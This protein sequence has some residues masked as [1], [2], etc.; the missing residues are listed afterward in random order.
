MNNYYQKAHL[1]KSLHKDNNMNNEPIFIVG[2]ERSGTTLFRLMLSHHPKISVC[3]EFEYAVDPI[4]FS[5]RLNDREALNQ[6]SQN[7]IFKSHGVKLDHEQSWS[8]NMQK[9]LKDFQ[10][11]EQKELSTAIVHKN[12][13]RLLR[14][15]P[16]AKFIHLYRDPRDVAKSVVNMGW[17]SHVLSGA[18]R[19]VHAEQCWQK[20][21]SEVPQDRF[22]EISFESLIQSP[23][24]E[25]NKVCRFMGIQ[26]DNNM[27]QYQK[28]STYQQPD[29]SICQS[30]KRKLNDSEIALLEHQLKSWLI[31]YNYGFSGLNP[32]KP[33]ALLMHLLPLKDWF[34]R[35][36][37]RLKLYGT[38][39]LSLDWSKRNLFLPSSLQQAL[40]QRMHS[41]WVK[42]LK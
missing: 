16:N 30:W 20:I 17:A 23:K 3:S 38:L 28:S 4:M 34:Y 42:S 21:S 24:S 7:W 1:S 19:W 29:K 27:M 11:N 8:Q 9:I 33:S 26:F 31:K 5:N 13:D 22:I 12:F 18:K 2:S 25:L 32:K 37:Q 6:L 10:F 15:W 39:N 36:T 35:F 41:C 14:I 40:D